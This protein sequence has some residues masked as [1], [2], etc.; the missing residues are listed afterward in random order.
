MAF[1]YFKIAKIYV[2]KIF[3]ESSGEKSKMINMQGFL[4]DFTNIYELRNAILLWVRDSYIVNNT[5]C[6]VL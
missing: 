2:N 4:L 5:L 1:E 6:Y 3:R